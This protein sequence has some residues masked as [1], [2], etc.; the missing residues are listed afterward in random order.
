MPTLRRDD[1]LSWHSDHGLSAVELTRAVLA[2][3]VGY[4]IF[5]GASL[6]FFALSGRDPHSLHELS[7]IV[8]AAAVGVLYSAL[9]GYVCVAIAGRA[10][11]GAMIALA[12]TITLGAVMLLFVRP[13]EGAVWSQWVTILLFA[14]AAFLGGVARWRQSRTFPD[15]DHDRP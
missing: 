6:L 10:A 11:R 15:V 3:A 1:H 13:G 5:A 7:F 4:V 9:A 14:P 2:V 12:V 8:M